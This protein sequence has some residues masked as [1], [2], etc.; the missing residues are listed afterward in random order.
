MWPWKDDGREEELEAR[1]EELE[2]ERDRYIQRFEAEKERRS[3]LSRK[4]QEAEEEL[5]RLKDKL[6]SRKATGTEKEDESGVEAEKASFENVMEL[7]SRLGDIEAEERDLLTV[8]GHSLQDIEDL[9][10]L[11]NSLAKSDYNVLV[12]RENFVAF[13]DSGFIK[14]AVL[15]RSFFEQGW[16]LGTGFDTGKF[17]EAVDE[18][19]TW[20]LVSAGETRVY[21]ESGGE[22]EEIETVKT[23][24]DS[25]HTQGGFSQ[26]RFERK[27][28]EQ[29][30]EHLDAVEEVIGDMENVKLLGEESL[31]KELPGEHLGG[32]DP[33]SGPL[34]A[35]YN[36][37]VL[38][39]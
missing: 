25:S 35:F 28:S 23:R 27:R 10:G 33:N 4:K 19:K 37:R 18:E 13:L 15:T 39:W 3:E 12:S 20:V 22:Y 36:F 8:Y 26:G 6:R 21:R 1:I 16:T 2:E 24:V 5:N 14:F 17:M 7:V 32:F 9:K 11:Q 38:R 31:C 29:V 34:E 30:E